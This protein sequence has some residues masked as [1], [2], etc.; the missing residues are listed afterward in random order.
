M[1]IPILRDPNDRLPI[2]YIGTGTIKQ[3]LLRPGDPFLTVTCQ[4]DIID[5]NNGGQDQ[6]VPKNDVVYDNRLSYRI[7]F[8]HEIVE[9]HK[10][11]VQK[12]LNKSKVLQFTNAEYKVSFD[13]HSEVRLVI[14]L[15]QD[16]KTRGLKPNIVVL[17]HDPRTE[18]NY[19]GTIRWT[20][21]S[22]KSVI[23]FEV[24]I[25]SRDF[26]NRYPTQVIPTRYTLNSVGAINL[27][28]QPETLSDG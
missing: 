11:Q 3:V 10:K 1:V 6:A 13:A 21:R 12:N 15:A 22:N 28:V 16:N 23:K 17:V 14:T 9:W 26:Q 25:Q 19:T 18:Q 5:P 4:I 8:D 27:T 7:I 2:S 20:D 24:V